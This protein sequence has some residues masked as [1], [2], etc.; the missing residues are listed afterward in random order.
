[1]YT[2]ISGKRNNPI[3]AISV[4]AVMAI[5][6]VRLPQECIPRVNHASQPV[7]YA[8]SAQVAE[9]MSSINQFP[10]AERIV[11]SVPIGD[12]FSVVADSA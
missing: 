8:V 12:D 4:Q 10:G 5:R 6:M 9:T 7:G 3:P 1:L 11:E 2:A